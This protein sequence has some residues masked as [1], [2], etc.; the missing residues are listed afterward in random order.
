MKTTSF[1][2]ACKRYADAHSLPLSTAQ[3]AFSRFFGY[4]NF[5]AALKSVGRSAD[6]G[7]NSEHF[8]GN[9][10]WVDFSKIEFTLLINM[11]KQK[12]EMENPS[13]DVLSWFSKSLTLLQAVLSSM[14]HLGLR[15]QSAAELRGY[16]SIEFLERIAHSDESALSDNPPGLGWYAKNLLPGFNVKTPASINS[17]M[18][19]QFGY[20]LAILETSILKNLVALE[21][22]EG[23]KFLHSILGPVVSQRRLPSQEEVQRLAGQINL[24]SIYSCVEEDEL[25]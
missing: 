9:H 23:K 14:D 5:D 18:R 20:R 22:S 13:Q 4:P 19:D 7:E 25:A 2:K 8:H 15:P 10:Y 16:L 12:F 24:L 11:L 3:E 21:T 17:G 1:K 6:S